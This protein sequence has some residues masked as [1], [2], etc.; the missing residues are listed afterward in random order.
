MENQKNS[1]SLIYLEKRSVVGLE[2]Q[3]NLGETRGKNVILIEPDSSKLSI[4]RCFVLPIDSKTDFNIFKYY[5]MTNFYYFSFYGLIFPNTKSMS[6][7]AL[8]YILD[9][10]NPHLTVGILTSVDLKHQ[11]MSSKD[12]VQSDSLNKTITIKNRIGD[13]LYGDDSDKSTNITDIFYF[14]DKHG[15]G[16]FN[17]SDVGRSINTKIID[18]NFVQE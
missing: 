9:I 15:Y 6:A 8:L 17:L 5:G 7:E 14:E 2:V 3:V 11:S 13:F 10:S 12:F 1:D 18:M 4:L 16:T